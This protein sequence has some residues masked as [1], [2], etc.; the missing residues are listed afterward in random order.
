MKKSISMNKKILGLNKKT[1]LI[2]LLL[3]LNAALVYKIM[4]A[5]YTEQTQ[6]KNKSV[7]YEGKTLNKQADEFKFALNEK[8]K[9]TL[10]SL[11]IE[12]KCGICNAALLMYLKELKENKNINI[13]L[14]YSGSENILKKIDQVLEETKVNNLQLIESKENHIAKSACW[15]VNGEGDVIMSSIMDVGD[16][17]GMELFFKKTKF[18][19]SLI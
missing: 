16:M 18:L 5:T 13:I 14:F 8:S 17:K 19:F 4:N 15:V 6:N 2:V 9:L 3:L 12:E 1:I 10:V 7:D 11:I